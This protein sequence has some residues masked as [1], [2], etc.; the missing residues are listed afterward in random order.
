MIIELTYDEIGNYVAQHFHVQLK[1]ASMDEKT[2]GVEYKPVKFMPSMS[3]RP[4]IDEC[5]NDVLNISYECSAPMAVI[6][7]GA[8]DHVGS[9]IPDGIDVNPTNKRVVLNLEQMDMLKKPLEFVDVEVVSFYDD[10]AAVSL[11]LK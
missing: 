4:H 2:I 7:S 8:V 6:I 11:R 10:H 3:I 1:I 5:H 9:L